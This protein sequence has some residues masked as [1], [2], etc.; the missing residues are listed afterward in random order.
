MKHLV[1]PLLIAI[2][3]KS[4]FALASGDHDHQKTEKTPHKNEA[5]EAKERAENESHSDGGKD[6]H[7]EQGNESVGP[8]KGIVEAD[9]H[10]GFKLSPEA[11][12]NFEIR[13]VKLDNSRAWTLPTSCVVRSGNEVNLFRLRNGFFKRIDFQEIRKSTN[14]IVVASPDLSAGDEVV[15]AGLGFLRIA[16]LSAFG[17]LAE[18]HSH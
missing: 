13:S 12:K 5:V 3:F 8:D 15:V 2:S 11:L 16:E 1:L 10:T 9:E 6:A 14:Q 18:G 17:G 4:H 7:E